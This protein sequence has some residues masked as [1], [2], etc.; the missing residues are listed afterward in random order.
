MTQT[1]MVAAAYTTSARKLRPRLRSAS[2]FRYSSPS[3]SSDT[4]TEMA[5]RM[6]HS[7]TRTMGAVKANFG[8]RLTSYTPQYEP[9]APSMYAFHG[10][11]KASMT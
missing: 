2:L 4:A 8:W 11:S 6:C 7:G 1:A 3:S 5:A 10:W 9:T